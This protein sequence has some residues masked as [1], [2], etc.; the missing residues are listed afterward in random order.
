M[1]YCTCVV[2][3]VRAAP[4]NHPDLC[5]NTPNN[6]VACHA[7]SLLLLMARLMIIVLPI[8]LTTPLSVMVNLTFLRNRKRLRGE[9]V[10]RGCWSRG[11]VHRWFAVVPWIVSACTILFTG[12][13]VVLLTASEKD[14]RQGN[15]PC[16]WCAKRGWNRGW[17]GG[18]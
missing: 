5:C 15:L 4:T 18:V 12:S 9:R 17:E 16:R 2:D 10:C 1:C 13:M 8:V 11:P 3:S 14:S 7:L 6:D